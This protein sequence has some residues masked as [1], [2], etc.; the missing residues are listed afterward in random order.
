M[1]PGIPMIDQRLYL[2]ILPEI[3]SFTVHCVSSPLQPF[4]EG[5][6]NCGWWP[7]NPLG[8]DAGFVSW[9]TGESGKQETNYRKNLFT[10]SA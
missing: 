2:N 10:I 6:R 8:T 1:R 3:K 9:Q 5:A 4:C 7:V